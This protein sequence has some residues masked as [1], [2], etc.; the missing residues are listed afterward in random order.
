M[1]KTETAKCGVIIHAA[2]LA[3]AGVG[4][5]L[6]QAPCTDSAI[7][8]PIQMTMTISLGRVF[9]KKLS[10]SAAKS[11]MATGTATM[12][13][14]TAS[15]VAAGWVPV[16]GN[17]INAVTAAAVTEALGWLLASEFEKDYAALAENNSLPECV[18][19]E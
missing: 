19:G 13:G 2:S 15:Q 1:T 7:I 9:G 16:A 4:A 14:R 18:Q 6:A 3:A 10:A 8:T 11:V 17:V 12:I 5:G